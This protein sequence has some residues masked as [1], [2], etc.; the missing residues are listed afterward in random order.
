MQQAMPD[1]L[2]SEACFQVGG[3]RD[4]VLVDLPASQL[5]SS[6]GRTGDPVK[7]WRGDD[8]QVRKSIGV[9]GNPIWDIVDFTAEVVVMPTTLGSVAAMATSDWA[10]ANNPSFQYR[11]LL[12]AQGFD[13]DQQDSDPTR[14]TCALR[15]SITIDRRMNYHMWNFMIMQFVLVLLGMCTFA[16]D[17]CAI[18]ARLGLAFTMVL[19][20]NVFQILLVENLPE[21]GDLSRL[22][23]FTI[24]NT[25]VLGLMAVES[26]VVCN[27]SIEYNALLDTQRRL[28]QYVNDADAILCAVR[29]Q[30][31]A[32]RRQ[33]RRASSSSSSSSSSSAAAEGDVEA[34]AEPSLVRRTRAAIER[35]EADEENPS[36]VTLYVLKRKL[37]RLRMRCVAGIAVWGDLVSAVLIFPVLLALATGLSLGGVLDNLRSEA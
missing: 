29:L 22:Q 6:W 5:G 1:V 31:A 15:L 7:V 36:R 8:L 37:E 3:P 27:C 16:V 13:F 17:P 32:R 33:L 20:I 9:V 21:M 14:S 35:A 28:K 12:E 25:I 18:D 4:T 10:T 24:M 19:A 11:T 34:G 30:R 23:W 2:A 26:V